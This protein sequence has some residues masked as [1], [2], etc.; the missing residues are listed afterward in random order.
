MLLPL[1]LGDFYTTAVTRD[2]M[3]LQQ[4]NTAQQLQELY[5]GMGLEQRRS[6]R[7]CLGD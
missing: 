2:L 5:S 3:E 1:S 6:L 7:N 4:K